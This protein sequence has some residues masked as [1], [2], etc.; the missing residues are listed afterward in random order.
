M[1]KQ[2]VTSWNNTRQIFMVLDNFYLTRYLVKGYS[3]VPL[4]VIHLLKKNCFKIID[5]V[6]L[7]F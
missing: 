6:Y 7:T 5:I 3:F 1:I 2:H 4:Q